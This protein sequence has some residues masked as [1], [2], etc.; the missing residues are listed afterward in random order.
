MTWRVGIA[1]FVLLSTLCSNPIGSLEQRV[2]AEH[3]VPGVESVPSHQAG[4]R[5]LVKAIHSDLETPP[6][7]HVAPTSSPVHSVVRTAVSVLKYRVADAPPVPSIVAP[8][9]QLANPPPPI[10]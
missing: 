9:A 10:D 3:P 1:L 4:G 7:H 5:L 6:R 2:A 8:S